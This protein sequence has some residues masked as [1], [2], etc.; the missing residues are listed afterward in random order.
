MYKE[1]LLKI[2]LWSIG[3]YVTTGS[4]CMYH[5]WFLL[6]GHSQDTHNNPLLF[7]MIIR[8]LLP[9]GVC[10]WG[11]SLRASSRAWGLFFLGRREKIISRRSKND[12]IITK[13]NLHQSAF[14][15]DFFNEDIEISETSLQALVPF[16]PP[17]KPKRRARCTQGQP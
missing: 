16:P 5:K 15:A 9:K 13:L 1:N 12:N 6:D 14:S 3:H 11:G 4:P 7:L 8:C 2:K 17:K 10:L